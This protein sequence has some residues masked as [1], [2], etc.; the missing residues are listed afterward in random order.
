MATEDIYPRPVWFD[1]GWEAFNIPPKG[2]AEAF[3]D[4]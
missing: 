2:S 1:E 4:A 3:I